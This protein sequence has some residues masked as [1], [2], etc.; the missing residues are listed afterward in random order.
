MSV[1]TDIIAGNAV[2]DPH[3]TAAATDSTAAR[4]LRKAAGRTL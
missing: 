2:G 1:R 3:R 4:Q